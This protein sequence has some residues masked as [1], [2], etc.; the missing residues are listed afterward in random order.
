MVVDGDDTAEELHS[1][2]F[3]E[4]YPVIHS[5][6]HDFDMDGAGIEWFGLGVTYC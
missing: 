6:F 1:V 5:A 3:L 2:V 4:S